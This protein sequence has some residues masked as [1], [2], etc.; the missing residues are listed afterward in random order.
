[1]SIVYMSPKVHIYPKVSK[2]TCYLWG[3]FTCLFLNFLL[4]FVFIVFLLCF[5]LY[6]M[7]DWSPLGFLSLPKN[8][9]RF[10][11]KPW[12]HICARKYMLYGEF[13]QLAAFIQTG[14][15]LLTGNRVSNEPIM[16]PSGQRGS[17][18]LVSLMRIGQWTVICC[19][20]RGCEIKIK[21]FGTTGS[22]WLGAVIP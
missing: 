16:N 5:V 7:I 3:C 8:I 14:S 1:M 10:I 15:I 6:F 17:K 12:A 22:W 4:C 11:H 19:S 2:Y 20:L 18:I 21:S 9:K 13:L